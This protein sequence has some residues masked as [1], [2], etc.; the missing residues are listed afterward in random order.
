MDYFQGAGMN[1][2]GLA[3]IALVL[4]AL[5][6][7]F[8]QL[9]GAATS[10]TPSTT[11]TISNSAPSVDGCVTTNPITLGAGPDNTTVWCNCTVYDANGWAD[12]NFSNAT[13][14]NYTN[15]TSGYFNTSNRYINYSCVNRSVSGD[16]NRKYFNCS[17]SVT[18]FATP[19][20]G[21]FWTCNFSVND[22]G[23][24]PAFNATNTTLASLV[25]VG[26]DPSTINYGSLS[27]GAT[28]AAQY[29]NV[30]NFGNVRIDLKIEGINLTS[31]GKPD[32]NVSQQFYA[33][34][35]SMS[36]E[37]SVNFTGGSPQ[38]NSTYELSPTP[39]GTT[40]I[41]NR[42]QWFDLHV[43]SAQLAGTY[44]GTITLTAQEG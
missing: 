30:T 7:V 43:P 37:L 40:I 14:Y 26:N 8:Y 17:F 12:V 3:V 29:D 44:G 28:S 32:I 39:N 10:Q 22:T 15:T 35:S 36:G 31:S 2:V 21:G 18:Y 41:S 42:T 5:V 33:Y 24:Y 13:F 38:F 23:G 19:S 11:V 9:T 20:G 1:K 27:P 34:L 16:A 4:I 6:L 25:A